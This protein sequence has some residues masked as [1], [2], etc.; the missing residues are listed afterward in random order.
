MKNKSVIFLLILYYLLISAGCSSRTTQNNL[1]IKVINT[2][3][4]E[5]MPITVTIKV[6]NEIVAKNQKIEPGANFQI[7]RKLPLGFHKIYIEEEATRASVSSPVTTHQ[8]F[9][10]EAGF[11]RKG[12]GIGYFETKMMDKLYKEEIENNDNKEA[13]WKNNEEFE[14]RLDKQLDNLNT[15]NKKKK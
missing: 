7:T 3:Q 2:E 5:S 10:Y 9:W 6:D 14:N 1:N 13:D 4:T 8:E 11:H 12:K 15:E